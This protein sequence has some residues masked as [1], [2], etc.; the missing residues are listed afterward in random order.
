[1]LPRPQHVIPYTS[2]HCALYKKPVFAAG[3]GELP[4]DLSTQVIDSE[5]GID[6]GD[7]ISSLDQCPARDVGCASAGVPELDHAA[8]SPQDARDIRV[9]N[10]YHDPALSLARIQRSK[11]R[12][13]AIELRNSAKAVQSCST[14]ENDAGGISG[15]AIASLQNDHVVESVSVNPVA[16][17][18]ASCAGEGEKVGDCWSKGNGSKFYSGRITRSRSSSQ[19][20]GSLDGGKSPYIFREDGGIFAGSVAKLNEQSSHGNEPLELTEPSP[21]TNARSRAKKGKRGGKWS[22]DMGSNVSLGGITSSSQEPN[23]MKKSKTLDSCCDNEKVDG[24][25]DSKQHCDYDEESLELVK[26][27]VITA[28]GSGVKGKMDPHREEWGGN[29]N[30]GRVLR[31][32][33]P[34]QSHKNANSSTQAQPMSKSTPLLQS[35]SFQNGQHPQISEIRSLLRQKDQD[36][37]MEN[38][39]EHSSNGN[40]EVNHDAR[41]SDLQDSSSSKISSKEVYSNVSDERVIRYKFLGFSKSDEVQGAQMSAGGSSLK[42]QQPCTLN[43]AFYSHKEHV[44]DE[45]AG[46]NIRGE[47]ASTIEGIAKHI[48][49][50]LV[51]GCKVTHSRSNPTTKHPFA[52]SLKCSEGIDLKE[53]SGTQIKVLHGTCNRNTVEQQ[54]GAANVM[55]CEVDSDVLADGRSDLPGSNCDIACLRAGSGVLAS[56]PPSDCTMSMKPNQLDFDSVVESSSNGMSCPPSD[57]EVLGRLS[58]T[59]ANPAE[60]MKKVASIGCQAKCGSSAGKPSLKE[61]DDLSKDKE[62]QEFSSE[63]DETYE[64]S[65]SSDEN[66]V[67][68]I[69]RTS[70]VS[71]DA[72]THPLFV[73]DKAYQGKSSLTDHS[74]ILQV[75]C[76]DFLGSLPNLM[77]SNMSN[78]NADTKGDLSSG[79]VVVEHDDVQSIKLVSIN[80]KRDIS[81]G[82]DPRQSTNADFSFVSGSGPFINSDVTL[83]SSTID[84]P[85]ALWVEEMNDALVQPIIHPGISQSPK[86]DSLG[87]RACPDKQ[88]IFEKSTEDQIA[89]NATPGGSYSLGLEGSWFQHKRR[90][91]EGRPTNLLSASPSLREEGLTLINRGSVSENLNDAEDYSKAVLQ[92]LHFSLSP[93]KGV[94]QLDMGNSL[95]EAKHQNEEGHM[96]E[97]FESSP[98]LHVEEVLAFVA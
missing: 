97:G 91:I 13:K 26:S 46:T 58:G 42:D 10:I 16:T 66:A 85:R 4:N 15:S 37:C 52:Q 21:I 35:L 43:A 32:R 6:A 41:N 22:K 65:G 38:V 59:F 24:L 96:I 47:A 81:L 70:E 30:F 48:N 67:Q 74:S 94:A 93:E 8:M 5:Q 18:I 23:C 92:T 31:A 86:A 20:L 34:Y 77:G 1:M 56:R 28:D 82:G 7:G 78:V 44:A 61:Q 75:D 9:P 19:Q 79:K 29:D 87:R 12:Q 49:S 57:K 51:L 3:N 80:R 50:S 55:K 73:R 64:A 2:S 14:H 53:V 25:S 76:E 71:R 68:Q 89:K 88:V 83:N 36:L 17:N 27:S 62:L 98:R 72:V 54:R 40:S 39:R 11:S 69:K 33:G 63:V 60:L 84:L 90:K 45:Y 95:A